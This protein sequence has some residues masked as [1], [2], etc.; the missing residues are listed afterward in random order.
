MYFQSITPSYWFSIMRNY[1][2]YMGYPISW[3][4]PPETR[5]FDIVSWIRARRLRWLGHIARLSD[6]DG[7]LLKQTVKRQA[8][9]RTP[10]GGRLMHGCAN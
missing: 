6:K 1:M 7:N 4:E 8:Y 10:A 2:I 9:L 5:T 3:P